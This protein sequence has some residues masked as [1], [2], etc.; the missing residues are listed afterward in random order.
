MAKK[1][2]RRMT[3]P[4]RV[5]PLWTLFGHF[6]TII[7]PWDGHQR[8][9]IG[10]G[11]LRCQKV[12]QLIAYMHKNSLLRRAVNIGQAAFVTTLS[13][14]SNAVFSLDLVDLSSDSA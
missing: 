4:Y 6:T 7:P 12:Q 1:V 13:L 2:S 3:R 11:G 8:P 14:L 10:G 9:H 5:G